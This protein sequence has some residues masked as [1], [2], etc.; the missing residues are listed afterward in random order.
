MALAVCQTATKEKN[1]KNP[2]AERLVRGT[3]T[4]L[5]ATEPLPQGLG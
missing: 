3:L 2:G 5:A 1:E 4:C